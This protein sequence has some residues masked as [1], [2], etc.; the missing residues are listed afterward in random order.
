MANKNA[1][2]EKCREV[3]IQCTSK[4]RI[5][6][7]K[8]ILRE[9]GVDPDTLNEQQQRNTSEHFNLEQ[10]LPII[11]EAVMKQMSSKNEKDTTKKSKQKSKSKRSKK[12][13]LV[14]LSYIFI[15]QN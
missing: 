12:V 2:L 6:T 8:S 3:G 9:K 14:P 4:S 13:V 1:I 10:Q 5:S 11:V 15:G 7:L